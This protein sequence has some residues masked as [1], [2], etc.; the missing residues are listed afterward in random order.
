MKQAKVYKLNLWEVQLPEGGNAGVV[1]D[2]PA[3][4]AEV[5]A[6]DMKYLWQVQLPEDG[7]EGLLGV[8]R[9]VPSTAA[10]SSGEAVEAMPPSKRRYA[11]AMM[12]AIKQEQGEDHATGVVDVAVL[13]P[14]Q[15]NWNLAELKAKQYRERCAEPVKSEVKPFMVPSAKKAPVKSEDK[16]PV[17]VPAPE[18]KPVTSVKYEPTPAPPPF[19][20]PE[21]LLKYE[22]RPAPPPFAPPEHLCPRRTASVVSLVSLGPSPPPW[23]RNR[24]C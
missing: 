18:V 5:N 6:E 4:L 8:K 12:K 11:I 16:P 1:I 9:E 14:Y 3:S 2:E 10:S 22:P 23:Q 13:K 21:H 7:N 17:V 19:A 20:P 15:Q 24:R